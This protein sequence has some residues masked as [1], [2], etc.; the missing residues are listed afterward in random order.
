[1]Q[2][3]TVSLMKCHFRLTSEPKL[4]EWRWYRRWKTNWRMT[5]EQIFPKFLKADYLGICLPESWRVE[6]P[7]LKMTSTRCIYLGTIVL[8]VQWQNVGLRPRSSW[9][10]PRALPRNSAPALQNSEN[11]GL[12]YRAHLRILVIWHR[13]GAMSQTFLRIVEVLLGI[14]HLAEIAPLCTSAAAI[15]HLP[16]TLPTRNPN[17]FFF[18]TEHAICIFFSCE[19]SVCFQVISGIAVGSACQ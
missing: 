13:P 8:E 14:V 12:G 9:L 11:L 18:F 4:D 5:D 3:Q 1:M 6:Y 2:I 15:C 7:R 17:D 10:R 19:E 16:L